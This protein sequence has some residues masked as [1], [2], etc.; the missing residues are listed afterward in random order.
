MPA[1]KPNSYER[2]VVEIAG[3][4]PSL[5]PARP[6]RDIG[7]E[8]MVGRGDPLVADFLRCLHKIPD[9]IGFAADIDNRQCHAKLHLAAPTLHRFRL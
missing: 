8:H 2:V 3:P 7:T 9:R 4:A 6:A 5:R 1:R